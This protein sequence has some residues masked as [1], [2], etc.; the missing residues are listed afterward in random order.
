MLFKETAELASKN[1]SV[2]SLSGKNYFLN[3]GISILPPNSKEIIDWILTYYNDEE[4]L[5]IQVVISDGEVKVSEAAEPM[6]PSKIPLD[7]KKIKTNDQK[8]LEK[9]SAKFAEFKKPLSQVIVLLRQEEKPFWRFSFVTKTLEV[10]TI[11]IDAEK[12]EITKA[13]ASP[14][15]KA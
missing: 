10:V 2:K 1:E 12:G 3:A 7:V 4:N 6:N 14:L 8:M 11:E 9:A 13:E 15:T 5:I